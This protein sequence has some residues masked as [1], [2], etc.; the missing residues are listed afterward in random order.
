[1]MSIT[2]LTKRV[3]SIFEDIDD[4]DVELFGCGEDDY[5]FY[6]SHYQELANLF[7]ELAIIKAIAPD[8]FEGVKD[9]ISEQGSIDVPPED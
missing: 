1:M 8:A 9:S 5:Q 2:E 3:D 4:L 7:T 6:A